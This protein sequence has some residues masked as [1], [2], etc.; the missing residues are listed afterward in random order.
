LNFANQNITTYSTKIQS[1]QKFKNGVLLN[2][3]G[4]FFTIFFSLISGIIIIHFEYTGPSWKKET[5]LFI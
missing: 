1:I 4:L 2:K 5:R 3:D